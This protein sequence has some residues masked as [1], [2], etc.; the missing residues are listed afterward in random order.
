MK[1]GEREKKKVKESKEVKENVC[2]CVCECVSERERGSESGRTLNGKN[3]SKHE[4]DG[5][6]IEN[7]VCEKEKV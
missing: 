2:V 4:I 6:L 3:M 1:E 5:H 7:C